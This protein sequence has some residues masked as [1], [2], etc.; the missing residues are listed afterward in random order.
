CAPGGYGRLFGGTARAE[1]TTTSPLSTPAVTEIDLNYAG[2]QIG[3]D[4]GC[5]NIGD[6]GAAMNVGLLVGANKGR[7]TQDQPVPPMGARLISEND[8]NS[9]YFGAY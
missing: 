6:S 4:F 8:F 2:A 9:R 7:S 3:V 1:T 5:F